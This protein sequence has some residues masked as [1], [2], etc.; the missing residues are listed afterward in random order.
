[1]SYHFTGIMNASYWNFMIEDRTVENVL[2]NLILIHIQ[3]SAIVI[4]WKKQ[5]LLLADL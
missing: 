2:N 4:S 3:S 1:M 5:Y